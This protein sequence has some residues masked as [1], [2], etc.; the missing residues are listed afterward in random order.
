MSL[1][2]HGDEDGKERDHEYLGRYSDYRLRRSRVLK[3]PHEKAARKE[4][5]K[6]NRLAQ[7]ENTS[8]MPISN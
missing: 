2:G 5:N 7:P 4:G 3:D 1:F 6:D 8:V